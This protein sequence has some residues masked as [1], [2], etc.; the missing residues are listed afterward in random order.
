ML[1]TAE[2]RHTKWSEKTTERFVGPDFEWGALA[3][4]H[5]T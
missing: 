4:V 5:Y 1:S 3:L 2:A